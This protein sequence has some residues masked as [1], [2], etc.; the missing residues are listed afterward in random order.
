MQ[1]MQFGFGPKPRNESENG[2]S[3]SIAPSKR[4]EWMQDKTLLPKRP[5]TK[6]QQPEGDRP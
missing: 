3:Y 2:A 6:Q 1:R 4:P 5:P